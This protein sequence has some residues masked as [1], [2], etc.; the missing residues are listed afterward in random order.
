ME[1]KIPHIHEIYFI[2]IDIINLSICN[3]RHNPV[4]FRSQ[5]FILIQIPEIKKI[6]SYH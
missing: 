1:M 5:D 4:T 3:R 2:I 6:I